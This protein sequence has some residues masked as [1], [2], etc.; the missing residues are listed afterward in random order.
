MSSD[1]LV[2]CVDVVGDVQLSCEDIRH[3]MASKEPA[4]VNFQEDYLGKL[5]L[6][7]TSV[8]NGEA[9]MPTREEIG[10]WLRQYPWRM[11]WWGEHYALQCVSGCFMF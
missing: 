8:R 6:L 7:K 3:Y 5:A 10:D 11:D 1:L 2:C 9:T 4:D